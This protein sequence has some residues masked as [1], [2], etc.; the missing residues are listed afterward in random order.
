MPPC[1]VAQYELIYCGVTSS[2]PNSCTAGDTGSAQNVA[3]RSDDRSY[4]R[5]SSWCCGACMTV[6]KNV[7]PALKI[8][9]PYRSMIDANRPADVNTGAPSA[10]TDVTRVVSAAEIM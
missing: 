6:L 10:S 4:C 9:T 7:P 1:S 5:T 2:I 8:V 3:T